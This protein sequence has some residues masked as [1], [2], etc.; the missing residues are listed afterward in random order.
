MSDSLDSTATRRR[1]TDKRAD[2]VRRLSEAAA[3]VVRESPY[4][5]LT[6][7]QIAT[8]AGV[9][10]ATAYVYFSSKEHILAEVY[11]RRLVDAPPPD[12]AGLPVADRVAATFRHL[13][14]LGAEN[15]EFGRAAARALLSDDP[16]V[17]AVRIEV[18]TAIHLLLTRAAGDDA[19]PDLVGL[20]ELAYAGAIVRAG[21]GHMS[22]SEVAD[23]LTYAAHT[24]LGGTN[25]Q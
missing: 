23:S 10:R 17:D 12:L 11:R 7:Q 6:F 21:T 18:N 16:D 3:E 25:A 1:L 2:T 8:R 24:V 4:S 20:L 15:P 19:G 22:Y 13:A 5:D 9:T 14:L